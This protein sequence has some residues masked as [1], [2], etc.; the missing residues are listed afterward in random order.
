MS[1][2]GKRFYFSCS[3]GVNNN[4]VFVLAGIFMQNGARKWISCLFLGESIGDE[5]DELRQFQKWDT[6]VV[7]LNFSSSVYIH[8]KVVIQWGHFDAGGAGT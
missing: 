1:S 6:N 4:S 5:M 2:W 7:L 8:S 3:V